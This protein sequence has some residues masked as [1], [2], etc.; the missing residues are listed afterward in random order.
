ME[1]LGDEL[2]FGA[3]I[4]VVLG[5]L[6]SELEDSALPRGVVGSALSMAYPK[7]TA[8]HCM[9]LSSKGEAVM[10]VAGGSSWS[11]LKSCM[12]LLRAGVDILYV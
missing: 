11:F 6:E 9:M 2:H 3:L 5:E 12:S 7:I 4:R 8:C 1:H 10:P